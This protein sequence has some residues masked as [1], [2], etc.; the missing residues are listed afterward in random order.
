MRRSHQPSKQPMSY[1]IQAQCCIHEG[2][3]IIPIFNSI[4]PI[5]YINI[6][7]LLGSIL[8]CSSDINRGLPRDLFPVGLTVNCKKNSYLFHSHYKP[9]PYYGNIWTAR[10][11]SQSL[12]DFLD[13][14]YSY[15][16]VASQIPHD[17]ELM[18]I[19]Y[20]GRKF[21]LPHRDNQLR[22]PTFP[23]LR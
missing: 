16:L 2:S 20:S 13:W 6:H 8:I 18:Q 11:V 19:P 10:R 23:L 7:F 4:K 5:S 9:C 3:P 12:I 21:P 17:D 1:G 14:D 22:I 15:N